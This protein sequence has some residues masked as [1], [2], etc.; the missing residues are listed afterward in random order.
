L[1]LSFIGLDRYF[2][3][4]KSELFIIST[5]CIVLTNY[6]FSVGCLICLFVY[7]IYRILKDEEFSWKPFF[8]SA[9]KTGLLFVVPVLIC[10]FFLLPTIGALLSGSRPYKA[11]LDQNMLLLPK[12]KNLFY[13]YFS[14]G[15]TGT[16]LIGLVGNILSKDTKKHDKFL[17]ITLLALL[18]VPII[19]YLL[20]GMLY[21]NPKVIIPF[22]PLYIYSF[23]SFVIRLK[24]R[25]EPIVIPTLIAVILILIC[26]DFHKEKGEVYQSVIFEIAL[27]TLLYGKT[28]IICLYTIV[29]LLSG[30]GECDIE[31]AS[32]AFVKSTCVNE[33]SEMM[34]NTESGN[35]RVNI[36]YMDRFNCNRSFKDAYMGV[37]SYSST[38][39]KHYLE[40]YENHMG[41]NESERNSIMVTGTRNELFYCFMGTRY[42]FAENDPGFLY[43]KV[44]G[45]NNIN[46]YESKYAYPVVYKSKNLVSDK[47]FDAVKFP[48][49]VEMLMHNTVVSEECNSEYETRIIKYEVEDSYFIE[50][51]EDQEYSIELDEVFKDKILYLTFNIDNTD[52]SFGTK[53]LELS[54]NGVTNLLNSANGTYYNENTKFEYVIPMENTNVLDIKISSG[55]YPIYGLEMYYQELSY[56]QYE[57]AGNLKFDE[58]EDTITCTVNAVEG[59]YLVTSIPYDKGF[60]ATI[61]GEDAEIEVVNK[62]FVGLKLK[63]G[64]NEVVL[65]YDSP[66]LNVGYIISLIGIAAFIWIVIKE[67]R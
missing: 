8:L 29:F 51:E 2:E 15:I 20:N 21:V 42:I 9:F 18:F 58:N 25:K 30:L 5:V 32:K 48:Y 28:K 13:K 22:L 26:A 39:N 14:C 47:T 31:Y 23:V 24:E 40:F 37:S 59:E 61:N 38:P 66:L 33:I 67:K 54:I 34:E 65:N 64:K 12:T 17:N 62:A 4:K 19:A 49:N 16:M 52:E 46:M 50:Q 60:S 6:Y 57:E 36:S 10:A 45:R 41:N 53:T 55:I 44:D 3:K 56:E 11:E 27:F 43:E 7:A 1:L 35:Y 63:D